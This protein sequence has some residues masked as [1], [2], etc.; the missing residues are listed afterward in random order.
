MT[1]LVFRRWYVAVPLLAIT[2]GAAVWTSLTVKPDY[3]ATSYVQ[4]IPPSTA[5]SPNKTSEVRNP[6]LDLGLGSLNTAATYATVDRTFLNQLKASGLSD[7]VTITDGYPAPIATV[8]VIGTSQAQASATMDQVVKHFSGVVKTLQDD[9]AVQQNGLIVTRRLDTGQNLAETGGKV[10][11]ALIAVAG[12]GVLVTVG[13]T[14]GFDAALRRRARRRARRVPIFNDLDAP[15]SAIP[16]SMVSSV[17]QRRSGTV[18]TASS[19]A[20]A[21]RPDGTDQSASERVTNHSVAN[22]AN[23]RNTTDDSPTAPVGSDV[24]IVLPRTG[25]DRPGGEGGSAQR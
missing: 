22:Q 3:K 23:G 17:I 18:H 13:L 11:R 14:I 9:Y 10:K 2:M 8:E 16:T 7:N 1:K 21:D 19:A 6:W 12:A 15:T 5:A 24:T 4:L 25:Y 20:D